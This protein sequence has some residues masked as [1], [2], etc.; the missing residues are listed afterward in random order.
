MLIAE[1][2][3]RSV[4]KYVAVFMVSSFWIVAQQF[5]SIPSYGTFIQPKQ[6]DAF[7]FL[8]VHFM[9]GSFPF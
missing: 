9:F 1:D 7:I 5:R 6:N 8:Q 2:N 4:Y 3:T